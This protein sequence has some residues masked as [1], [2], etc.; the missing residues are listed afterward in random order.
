MCFTEQNEIMGEVKL[1]LG[2]MQLHEFTPVVSVG[3][4]WI[5]DN[6]IGVLIC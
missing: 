6:L 3:F 4:F 1:G 2:T 5:L